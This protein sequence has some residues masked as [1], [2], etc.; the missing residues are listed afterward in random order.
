MTLILR[1]L[2][3]V[4]HVLLGGAGVCRVGLCEVVGC[5]GKGGAIVRVVFLGADAHAA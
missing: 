5:W 3:A 1:R 4:S 2:D